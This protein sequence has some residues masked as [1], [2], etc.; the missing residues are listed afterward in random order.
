MIITLD[1]FVAE[2][3]ERIDK[4]EKYW[5]KNN[6]ENPE[7]FPNKMYSGEWDEQFMMFDEDDH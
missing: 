3:R 7:H 1:E 4:F 6:K 2:M 5:E